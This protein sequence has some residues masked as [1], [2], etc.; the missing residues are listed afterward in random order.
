MFRLVGQQAEI[1]KAIRLDICKQPPCQSVALSEN[2][3]AAK[4]GVSRTPI[5]QVL[6]LLAHVQLVETQAGVGTHSLALRQE[7]R[8]SHHVVM[9]ELGEVAARY[10]STEP[11]SRQTKLEFMT[12]K[13]LMQIEED[14]SIDLML[15]LSGR[16]TDALARTIDDPILCFALQAALWRMI[17]WRAHD[18][19]SGEDGAWAL[20]ERNLGM[21]ADAAVSGTTQDLL[22]GISQGAKRQVA[23]LKE[24]ATA[25]KTGT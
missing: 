13:N 15:D 10:A 16:T 2:A 8:I 14:H 12:I 21:L 9:G 22:M 7:D 20:T 19:M 4:F 17:R 24:A 1:L 25:Q 6:Q 5:R 3:L 11:L 23:A 18:I